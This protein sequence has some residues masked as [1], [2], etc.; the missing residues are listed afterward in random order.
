MKQINEDLNSYTYENS[1]Y[2]SHTLEMTDGDGEGSFVHKN[3]YKCVNISL[4][5][6]CIIFG[7]D[8]TRRP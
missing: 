6:A 4:N 2:L 3:I 7:R 1:F 8:A 5:M